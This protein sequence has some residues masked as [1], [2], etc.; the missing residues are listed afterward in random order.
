LTHPE[1]LRL[2]EEYLITQA[3]LNFHK[4]N[5]SRQGELAV[6]K[7]GTLKEME[8]AKALY[9]EYQTR[10]N[11]LKSQLE[12]LHIDPGSIHSDSL[13]K[14]I[15]LYAPVSGIISTILRSPGELS[16]ELHPVMKIADTRY[17]KPHFLIGK[18]EK[19]SLTP[20]KKIQICFSGGSKRTGRIEQPGS[21]QK[22]E[23][24]AWINL[25]QVPANTF[26]GEPVTGKILHD[27]LLIPVVWQKSIVMYNHENWIFV[28][29]EE[30]FKPLQ[31][32]VKNTYQDFVVLDKPDNI[33][34]KKIVTGGSNY[35]KKK[36][37]EKQ[38]KASQL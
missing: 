5:Y 24:H 27:S 6:D 17:L 8:K 23:T 29:E 25:D 30:G 26:P 20:G 28:Q 14:E 36:L 31:V 18:K 35:L 13:I 10:F 34:G 3:H 37:M 2:Q 12:M 32:E 9:E 4:T 1:Y 11:S 19:Y 33:K 7:A 21:T 22:S 15:T 16:D 38:T